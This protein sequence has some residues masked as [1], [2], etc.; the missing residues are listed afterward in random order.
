MAIEINQSSL[1]Y[2]LDAEQTV[3]GTIILQSSAIEQVAA[4]LLA[5][6]F[7]VGLHQQIFRVM[8]SMFIETVPIDL[9]TIIEHSVIENEKKEKVFD[10]QDEARS[11]LL[12][13]AESVVNPNNIADYAKIIIEKYKLRSLMYACRDI[14]DMAAAG[15]EKPSDILEAAEQRI[16]QLR[17]EREMGGLVHI[18]DVISTKLQELKETCANPEANSARVMP[19]SFSGIDYYTFGLTPGA[20]IIVAGR[21]GMGKTSFALNAAVGAAKLRPDKDVVIFSLEMT[22]EELVARVISSESSVSMSQMR[23]GNIGNDD[24]S[25]IKEGVAELSRLR[26]YIDEVG[27]LSIGEMKAKLRRSKNLGLVVIDYLQLMSI[28]RRDVNRT[29]EISEITRN[30]KLLAKEFGVPVVVASQLSRATEQRG[31]DKRPVLADLRDSGSIEQ[32]ADI[33]MFLHREGYYNE[34]FEKPWLCECIL[35]KNRQGATATVPLHWDGRYTK[36]STLDE[37]YEES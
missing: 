7:H 3:L 21:P 10:N 8:N 1:P 14:F 17:G 27:N 6:H 11:Y 28:G 32:D 22:R 33:V 9:V 18:K 30:L 15:A 20:L 34:A 12:K 24:W 19:S 2:S 4:F 23:N 16:Y 13:L 36:F 26:I 35:A 37:R 5:E 31:K 29:Q 25:N